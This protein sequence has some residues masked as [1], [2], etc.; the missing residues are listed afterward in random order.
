MITVEDYKNNPTKRRAARSLVLGGNVAAAVLLEHIETLPAPVE[1]TREMLRDEIGLPQT[2]H[3]TK[4]TNALSPLVSS[5]WVV[6]KEYGARTT[7][8]VFATVQPDVILRDVLAWLKVQ[9]PGER[10]RSGPPPITAKQDALFETEA[11]SPTPETIL[12]GGYDEMKVREDAALS[13]AL[14]RALFQWSRRLWDLPVR[15]NV[16]SAADRKQWRA[17]MADRRKPSVIAA[18]VRGMSFDS[19][20]GRAQAG[21]IGFVY[22]ERQWAKWLDL[23]EAHVTKGQP[24]PAKR[25]SGPRGCVRWRRI[26]IPVDY[27]PT[28]YDAAKETEGRDVF[29]IAT[30]SWADP[31]Y[32]PS[33]QIEKQRKELGA[34][35]LPAGPMP[36]EVRA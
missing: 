36:R 7:R 5:G 1:L 10:T 9:P 31:E 4:L 23:Y 30:R 12:S 16:I 11:L 35:N 18:A 29:I 19:W 3:G 15:D 26:W 34:V 32:D 14:C 20:E 2:T 33:G 25:A 17:W 6:T 28:E 27:R 22:V 8:R 21:A 24:A 13:E